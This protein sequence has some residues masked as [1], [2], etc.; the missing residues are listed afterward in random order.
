EYFCNMRAVYRV[1]GIHVSIEAR[2]D[3]Q[4]EAGDDT[5]SA[6]YRG[7]RARIEVRQGPAE[8][9]RPELY[10]LPNGDIAAA[11]KRR[12]GALA[13]EHPGIS[14]DRRDGEWRVVIPMALRLGH[15]PNFV[16]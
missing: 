7:S 5:H 14:L 15:D 10:V 11:L 8:K 12:I 16:A 2:W 13:A 1:R 3:W 6:V 9:Y 4:T